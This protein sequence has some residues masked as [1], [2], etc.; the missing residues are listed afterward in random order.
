LDGGYQPTFQGA[1]VIRFSF[2]EE[3]LAKHPHRKHSDSGT[4][5]GNSL[6]QEQH[7]GRSVEQKGN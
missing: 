4:I 5:I 7:D 1:F 2:S 3:K 6:L